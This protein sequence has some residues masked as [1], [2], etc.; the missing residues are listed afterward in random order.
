MENGIS[1]EAGLQELCRVGVA[2]SEEKDINKLLEMI[3]SVA[4]RYT[5]AEGC[6]LYL[7]N[8]EKGC[9]DFSVV[10]NERLAIYQTGPDRESDWP[11]V[12]LYLADGSE[13]HDNVSAHCALTGQTVHISDVYHDTGYDFRSTRVFD[14]AAGY[15]SCSMLLVPMQDKQ[16]G[17]I[18]VL[19][20]LN[21]RSKADAA[22]ID[23]PEEAVGMV[24]T[25]AS[26][27]SVSVVNVRLLN[28]L[29]KFTSLGVALSAEKNI[30]TLLEMIATMARQYTRAEGCT[31]YLCNE[32]RDV[33][34]FAVIQNE[35][36]DI[37]LMMDGEKREWPLISLYLEDGSEN[38]R[39]VS[40]HCVLTREIISIHD[41]YSEDG[42]DFSGTRELDAISDYRSQS[43]LLVPMTDHEDEVI[44]VLQLLNAR[45]GIS[46]HISEF[47][48]ED[49]ELVSGLA[50]QAAV[51]VTNVRL[52]KGMETLLNSFVQCIAA[53]ID[54]KSP[55]TAGHI[56]RV[57]RLTEM[58]VNGI[59]ATRT[60]P[61]ADVHF[62]EEQ[63]EEIN[64]AAWM[65][66]IGKITTP[67]Y[68]VDKT[69]KLETIFDRIEL[70]RLRVEL[71]RK[72]REIAGLRAG[73]IPASGPGWGAG[74]DGPDLDQIFQFIRRANIGGEF[75]GDEDLAEIE[76]IASLC[77]EL[78]G[79]PTPLLNKDEVECCSIRKGTL[80]E[81]ERQIINHHV[82]VGIRMLESLPFLKKW[83]RVPEYAGMHHEKLDG[84]GYPRGKKGE[85]ISL[86]A[87]ILAVADVF[88][89]LTAS[90]RP[91]TVG[92]N[93]SEALQI[94]EFMVKES[95]LD[96]TICDFLV[97]SGIVSQYVEEFL[98]DADK[99]QGHYCWNGKEYQDVLPV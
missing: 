23:F 53:A 19:Q 7:C 99:K 47:S 89:A 95:H 39:N 58:M 36:L 94:M 97:E 31:V 29:K 87:R 69:T 92:R 14:R 8:E 24:K 71:L 74:E 61:F 68:V 6:T 42:F 20:L 88:E 59:N 57:A 41:V 46:R 35:K 43:M 85:E 82:A 98:A 22:I 72:E 13:N 18:G 11:S 81:T 79:Q 65:H 51:A 40:A 37:S 67:E 38:H 93:L 10:Q 66:D 12:P 27:A 16:G 30:H 4:R 55:Y 52:V 64:L 80:T 86:L 60:G 17:V 1:L 34:E 83:A 26:Q 28:R 62:S 44:G 56:Q 78:D 9:L 49:I 54:E 70:V 73:Q 45:R 63:R 5:N 32:V 84:S 48:E 33:L 15:R 76:R 25:L 96:G 3:A 90:D 91:Y 75:M 21:A 77:F 50:S 2:L